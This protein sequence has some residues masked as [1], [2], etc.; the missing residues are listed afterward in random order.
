MSTSMPLDGIEY[1]TLTDDNTGVVYSFNATFFLSKYECTWGRGCQGCNNEAYTG[2]CDDGVNIGDRAE[3]VA[4][5]QAALKLTPDNWEQYMDVDE[6]IIVL[7]DDDEAVART[8][9]VNGRC[10][11][12]NT[13]GFFG[14]QGCALHAASIERGVDYRNEKPFACWSY[15]IRYTRVEE[16]FMEIGPV[17][18]RDHWA[19]EH[20]GWWCIDDEANFNGKSPAYKTLKEELTRMTSPEV[21]ERFHDWCEARRRSIPAHYGAPVSGNG[22]TFSVPVTLIR[23]RGTTQ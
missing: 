3:L 8:I 11:F 23:K 2:C 6:A 15:P 7:E 10:V 19:P 4:V 18:R 5:R 9:Q 17:L 13:D 21:Y 14:P 20:Y 16:G 22:R 1:V 12:I